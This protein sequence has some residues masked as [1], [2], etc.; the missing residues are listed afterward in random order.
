MAA[1]TL[2][3]PDPRGR[4]RLDRAARAGAPHRTLMPIAIITGSGGLIG[5]ES[6]RHFT[7]LGFDVVGLENDM[8]AHFF[9]PDASTQPVTDRLVAEL[10]G[11][12][13]LDVDIRDGEGVMD[14]F[15]RHGAAI[16]LVVHTAAQPSHDW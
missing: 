16:E 11:F 10:D 12:S 14:V 6:V 15:A 7:S 4:P 13:S 2:G 9:G 5:S 8:R 3:A 1:A